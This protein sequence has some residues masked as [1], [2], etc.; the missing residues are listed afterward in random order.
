MDPKTMLDPELV[1][2]LEGLMAAT[3]G[4]FNLR[5]IPATR[6][7]VAGMV[8]AVKAEVP[9]IE[10][11]ATQDLV[12]TMPGAEPEVPV[13][14][15]RPTGLSGALPA[16]LWMHPGGYVIGSI[17]LDDLMAR[18]LAKDVGCIVVS[19][20]YRLA[21]EHPFPAPLEDCYTALQWLGANAAKLHVDA[22]RIAVGGASAGGGLAAGLALLARDRKGVKPCL[23]LLIYPA[24]NDYNV[25]QVSETTPE[26]LFWSRENSLIGW[27][28]YL[29][30]RQGSVGVS[31]YAAAFRATD[32]SGLPPAYLAVGALDMFVS[33]CLHYTE[34][35]IAA[36][37]PTSLHVYP[38]AF[39]AFDAFAPMAQV[40]QRFVADRNAALQ[41][42]FA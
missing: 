33:D 38:G 8:E 34:R 4:G 11:V 39:H 5:D 32:L 9:P 20:E 35:L 28:E 13:R 3:G 6:A 30:N 1:E 21:P 31:P 19:V 2:P 22:D 17:E 41:R 15:Y 24:I 26:N 40:S 36:Y 16:L 14:V 42:A 23:Q 18:Q 27:Q 12:A 29:G 25:E 7:M 10:G 37:V